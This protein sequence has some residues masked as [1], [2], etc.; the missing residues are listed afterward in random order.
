MSF[1]V[2]CGA[3]LTFRLIMSS[4]L[5]TCASLHSAEIRKKSASIPTT[6]GG[7]KPQ[8]SCAFIMG[9]F[10]FIVVFYLVLP[11]VLV[12]RNPQVITSVYEPIPSYLDSNRATYSPNNDHPSLNFDTPGRHVCGSHCIVIWS[13]SCLSRMYTNMQSSIMVSETPPPAYSETGSPSPPDPAIADQL[14]PSMLTPF[15]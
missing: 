5:L 9:N 8:V 12:P 2:G 6:T 10:M 4:S 11:P 15:N 13:L 14:S 1:I 7:S 3:G